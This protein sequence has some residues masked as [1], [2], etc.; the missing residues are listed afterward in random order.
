M[1]VFRGYQSQWTQSPPS[2]SSLSSPG[3]SSTK[4]DDSSQQA[5]EA[6]L[7]LEA[8]PW[9]LPPKGMV[10]IA[11]RHGELVAF[12]LLL[13]IQETIGAGD[14]CKKRDLGAWARPSCPP[15]S[16][17]QAPSSWRYRLCSAFM[18]H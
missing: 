9:L 2:D 18:W 10:H 11:R 16:R 15:F 14:R 1:Q 6:Q 3:E 5:S 13:R 12:V 17:L 7:S 4:S 8:L